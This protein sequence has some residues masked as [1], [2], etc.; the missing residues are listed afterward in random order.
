MAVLG[1]LFLILMAIVGVLVGVTLIVKNLLYLAGPN[2]ALVFSGRPTLVEGKRVGYRVIKGG[3]GYRF[4]L[5]EAVD[6]LDLTNMIVDLQ[7]HNAYSK[8]GIPLTIVGVAN[9]KIS[10]HQPGLGHAI[11]RFMGMG[12]D[13]IMKIAKDTLEGNLRGVLSQL[14]PEAVNVDKIAFAEKL[15]EEAEHDLT[16][17]GLTL[18]TL[19]IQSVSD[20]VK[21]LDS[22]GR[23]KSAEVVK[24]ARIA[25]AE[26]KAIS[27]TRDAEN[28]QSARL[29][30]ITAEM[31]ILRAETERR[32]KDAQTR[33]MARVAEEI[34]TVK[35]QIARATADM[36]VAE[37][38]VEQVRRRLEADVIVPAL[39]DMQ[40][41]QA[42]AKGRAAKI[43]EDGK[44]TVAVLEQMIAT[45]K[46]GGENARDIFLMQKLQVLMSKLVGTIEGIKIDRVTMLPSGDGGSTAKRAVRFVEEMRGAVGVDLPAMAERITGGRPAAAPVEQR[47]EAPRVE[48]APMPLPVEAVTPLPP[49]PPAGH[50]IVDALST[51]V[52]VAE[53]AA[54]S[55]PSPAESFQSIA[56]KRKKV[57]RD[58]AAE[59]GEFEKK[60]RERRG[61]DPRA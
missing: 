4:P 57:R 59:L 15:L 43:L 34:G 3:R 51:L 36:K 61:T 30:E 6:Q 7:V 20:E 54:E 39:A 18:D 31:E 13:E 23:K 11:E 22:I 40:A 46:A 42:E 56:A 28:S 49:P 8:G 60:M 10:G 52:D 9:L 58:I 50:P 29:S 21:Y 33:K 26:A 32:I 1:T 55:H 19:K 53:K 14:T 24:K 12:R 45:W 25:E 35:A 37:A 44:A 47:V 16:K 38:Q 48:M 5:I 27:V 2:E 41:R 17:L